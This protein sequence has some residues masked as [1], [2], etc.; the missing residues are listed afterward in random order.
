MPR[1]DILLRSK[2]RL[3]KE[4]ISA[5]RFAE[6]RLVYQEICARLKTDADSWFTLGAINGMLRRHDEAVTCCSK[7]VELSPRHVAAWYNLG[8]ALRDSGQFE[9]SAEALRK[10]LQLDPKYAN[11]AP[12]LG[13]VLAVLH[14]YEEAEE[15]FREMLRYQPGNAEFYA[16]YGSSMQT[17]G[18]YEA[19]I[20]AYR[21]AIEMRHPETAEIHEN[22]GAALCMQGKYRESIEHFELALK[23]APRNPRFQSSLLLTLHY[24]TGQDPESLLD[25]HRQ[26]SAHAPRA[27]RTVEA[28]RRPAGRPDKLR[29]GYVSSDLRKHS[30]A[31]FVESLLAHHDA[32]R[33]EI[34]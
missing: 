31:Y 34:T 5:K 17:M 1:P 30:V 28:F 7:A 32:N 19:A 16:V 24:L 13:H 25:R 2:L 6:A 8:I 18:R 15:L 4:L 14:R 26:W 33:F 11:A 21:K 29:I 20:N 27:T 22:V 9:K 3:G 10:T 23:I 12:S